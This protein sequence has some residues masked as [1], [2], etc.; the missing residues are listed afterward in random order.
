M[1][2]LDSDGTKKEMQHSSIPGSVRGI[3]HISYLN[4]GFKR[5]GLGFSLKLGREWIQGK[6]QILI[7]AHLK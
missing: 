6:D 2:L 1:N 3:Y 5:L 4:G 7:F